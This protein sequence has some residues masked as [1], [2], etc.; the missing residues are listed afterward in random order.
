MEP[1]PLGKRE[2]VLKGILLL[3]QTICASAIV[4][5]TSGELFF[6]SPAVGLLGF[7]SDWQIGLRREEARDCERIEGAKQNAGSAGG[8]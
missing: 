3:F 1:D 5:R 2:R 6:E 8:R 7:L 4:E